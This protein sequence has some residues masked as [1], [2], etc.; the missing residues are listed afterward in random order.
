[1]AFR[2]LIAGLG[3]A[4]LVFTCGCHSSTARYQPAVCG[5]APVA[6]PAAPCYNRAP[7]AAI[8][9]QVPA[10]TQIPATVPPGTPGYGRY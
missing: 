8:P 5:T 2:K 9:A 4:A 7:V 6:A 10:G 3:V 1:M